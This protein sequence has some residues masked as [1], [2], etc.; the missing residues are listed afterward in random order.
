MEV[1]GLMADENWVSLVDNAA[2]GDLDAIADLAEAYYKGT[3]G[4]TDII[5]ARKWGMYAA[6]RGHMKAIAILAE[7][8]SKG[9]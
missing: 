9:M 8:E 6:K 4:Q 2:R 5:K 3:F 1:H 7:M